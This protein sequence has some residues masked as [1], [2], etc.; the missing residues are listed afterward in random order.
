MDR[1]A[2]ARSWYE[3][4]LAKDA[5]VA[6]RQ[7]IALI[8]SA[9]QEAYSFGTSMYNILKRKGVRTEPTTEKAFGFDNTTRRESIYIDLGTENIEGF[10]SPI[11]TRAVLTEVQTSGSDAARAGVE[12]FVSFQAKAAGADESEFLRIPGGT[13]TQRAVNLEAV[14][15]TPY[16]AYQKALT[17]LLEFN[18]QLRDIAEIISLK[19]ETEVAA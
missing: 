3:D 19:I 8:N 7:E 1:E 6:S 15:R 13:F 9:Y 11:A 5:P 2:I 12:R 10:E 16:E 4:R 17:D 18:Q 14:G